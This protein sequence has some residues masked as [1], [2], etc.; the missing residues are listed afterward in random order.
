MHLVAGICASLLVATSIACGGS[1]PSPTTPA[2]PAMPNQA[3]LTQ[4]GRAWAVYFAV[5]PH[6]APELVAAE[7]RTR[8]MGLQLFHKDPGCDVEPSDPPPPAPDPEAIEIMLLA[9]YYATEAEARQVAA[10]YGAP[11]P[12]VG[13]VKTMCLD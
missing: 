9:A 3:T 8:A 7:E 11:A 10:S 1:S 2:A 4:G 13:E 6:G 12:W 5:A